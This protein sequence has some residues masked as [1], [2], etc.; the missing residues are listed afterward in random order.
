VA[1]TWDAEGQQMHNRFE[2]RGCSDIWN[3]VPHREG[4]SAHAV[5]I[6][7]GLSKVNKIG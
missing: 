2:R 5:L 6:A 1:A 4:E 7:A 3:L